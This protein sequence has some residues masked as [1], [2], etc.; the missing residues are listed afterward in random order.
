ML[1][2]ML[3]HQNPTTAF[4]SFIKLFPSHYLSIIKNSAMNEVVYLR[5][6]KIV[7]LYYTVHHNSLNQRNS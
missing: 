1:R 4:Q 7:L 6:K 5:L 2:D 3:N